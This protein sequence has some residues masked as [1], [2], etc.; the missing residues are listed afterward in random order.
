MRVPLAEVVVG[1]AIDGVIEIVG[2]RV[3]GDLVQAIQ[4]EPRS[5][6]QIV[7]GVGQ[8]VE[9]QRDDSLVA[10]HR[11]AGPANV[12]RN[13]PHEFVGIRIE[14]LPDSSVATGR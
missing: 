14:R 9:R 2:P 4:I 5:C 8:N 6:E 13:R 7:V 1:P 10:A 12:Q 3:E 11:H